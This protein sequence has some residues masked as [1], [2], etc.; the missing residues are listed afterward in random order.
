MGVTKKVFVVGKTYPNPSKKYRETT[1]I[2]GVTD[3]G[4]WI[5]MY[6]VP[7]R[8]MPDDYKFKKYDWITVD[9]RPSKDDNRVESRKIY[10]QTIKVVGHEKSWEKRNNILLPLLNK[11]IEELWELRDN[12][13]KSMGLIKVT[14]DNFEGLTIE[15]KDEISDIAPDDAIQ[16]TLE[17]NTIP[18][19]EI[20]PYRFKLNF[21]CGGEDCKGH[22][23]S[24]FDWEMIQLYRRMKEKYMDED[25]AIQKIRDKLDWMFRERDVYLLL[26]TEFRW[27][28]FIIGGIY[29]PP[30]K[31]GGYATLDKWY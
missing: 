20:I 28:N 12:E 26:G 10:Y 24:C 22:S 18:P 21:Y 19:L 17:G 23:V 14:K 5:R 2:G 7:F 16:Q 4:K 30:K 11:S 1:C 3:E 27:G 29:Y 8:L 25:I 13:N 6:P 9:T 31:V 15:S